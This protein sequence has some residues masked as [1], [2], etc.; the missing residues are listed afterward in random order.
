MAIHHRPRLFSARNKYRVVI[1]VQ[2]FWSGRKASVYDDL[3]HTVARSR[4][5]SDMA[6]APQIEGID[7]VRASGTQ[8]SWRLSQHDRLLTLK[9]VLAPEGPISV[10]ASTWW[11]GV[12]AGRYPAPI[13]L[14]PKSPR[15]LWSDIQRLMMDGTR[16]RVS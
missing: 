15:W 8:T 5:Q 14:G 10:S 9:Q 3:L 11:D 6:D 2:L 13:Y 16:G 12:K 7:N 4:A 1:D